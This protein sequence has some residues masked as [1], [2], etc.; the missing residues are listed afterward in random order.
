MI[1][2]G[3]PISPLCKVDNRLSIE[4]SK[5]QNDIPSAKREGDDMARDVKN[6]IQLDE[7][8]SS[9]RATTTLRQETLL[10]ELENAFEEDEE[11]IVAKFD[12][13][14]AEC[15]HPATLDLVMIGG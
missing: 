6:L 14:R 2:I 5:A 10:D 11:S 1:R 15:I 8:T 9:K 3:N 4:V 7:R 13:L 12:E